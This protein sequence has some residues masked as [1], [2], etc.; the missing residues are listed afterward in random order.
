M[1]RAQARHWK[2]YWGSATDPRWCNH[3]HGD[4]PQ[5]RE[6]YYDLLAC[7]LRVL[8]SAP[9]DNVL[10]VGCGD[11][12]ISK[13][14]FSGASSYTGVD[15]SQAM[16]DKFPHFAKMR[17]VCADAASYCEQ[18]K[19]DLIFS[20]GVVQYLSTSML[21]EHLVNIRTMLEPS[22][23]VVFASMPFK[24]MEHRYR[25]GFSWESEASVKTFLRS[26]LRHLL[27]GPD[28]MGRWYSGSEIARYA[29][30]AGFSCKFF[31]SMLFTY[32][33]H[34]VLTPLI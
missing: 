23:K 19:F 18:R 20:N 12:A 22:G 30:D 9:F 21:K 14:L 16:L 15:L 6:E 31:G 29:S 28:A 8:L 7:E 1:P 4:S 17:L 24:P 10:D 26:R 33:F 2:E 13:R 25:G 34:A 5:A 27:R 3:L 32:R 11:G